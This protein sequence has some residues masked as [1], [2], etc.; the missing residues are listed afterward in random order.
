MQ[1]LSSVVS[2]LQRFRILAELTVVYLLGFLLTRVALLFWFADWRQ[3]RIVDWLN[4]FQAGF[5]FDLLIA[6]LGIQG[7]LWHFAWGRNHWLNT[8]PSR[9][10]M[11]F[12]WLFVFCF[13]PL[14]AIIEGLFFTEFDGRLNYIAFEYLVYP[15]EVC[16]N[17]WQSFPVVELVSVVVLFGGGMWWTMRQRF[18][19]MLDDQMPLRLRVGVFASVWLAI[20]SLWLTSGMGSMNV[21]SNRTANECTGKWRVRVPVSRLVMPLR[22]RA[23][24]SDDQAGSRR[25]RSS[26]AR[27]YGR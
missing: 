9:W 14:F 24:L 3:L 18:R 19:R 6:L 22:L 10:F 26:S 7:Q 15:T 1:S 25:G 5:R 27:D 13:V 2:R 21:T 11:E 20:A 23:V 4:V 12:C 17:I 8:R 16:C